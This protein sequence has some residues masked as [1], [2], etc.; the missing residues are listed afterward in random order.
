[1]RSHTLNIIFSGEL[2]QKLDEASKTKYISRSA[3]VRQA[4]AE[5]LNKEQVAA[6]SDVINWQKLINDR[7]S[8]ELT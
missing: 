8:Q 2:F 6:E 1:M 7:N 4:V 3:Y 5:K